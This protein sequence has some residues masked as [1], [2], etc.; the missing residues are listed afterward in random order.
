[1]RIRCACGCVRGGERMGGGWEGLEGERK[2]G[3]KNLQR[4]G[5]NGSNLSCNLLWLNSGD[6]H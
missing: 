5:Y 4:P 2:D 3:E 1:M 6:W